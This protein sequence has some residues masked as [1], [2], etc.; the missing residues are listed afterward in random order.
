MSKNL[1]DPSK[2]IPKGTL[3]AIGYT[4]SVYILLVFMLGVSV[5]RDLLLTDNLVMRKLNVYGPI[6]IAGVYTSTLSA[7]LICVVSAPNVFASVAKDR[8]VP[9]LTYFHKPNKRGK[10]CMYCMCRVH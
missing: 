5:T 3:A 6:V 2:N 4:G 7:G 8:I 9:F 10:P 1:R